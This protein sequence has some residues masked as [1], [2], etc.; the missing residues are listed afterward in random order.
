MLSGLYPSTLGCT[1]NGIEM[2]ED[3]WTL[4][5]ILQ[6]YG[7]HTANIGKL[8]FRNHS[9]R[10]H[11]EPHPRYGFD[12]LILSDEPG[13]Y[14]DAYIKWVAER[15]ASQVDTCRVSTP[16]AW[17]GV[18]V[19]KQPRNTHE[20]YLFEGPEDMTHS[21]FVSDEVVSFLK[22]RQSC[23]PFFAIAGFYAPHA[24]LNPPRRFVDMYDASVLPLP[25]KDEQQGPLPWEGLDLAD[26]HWQ[27]IKA[28]YYALITHVDDQIGGIFAALEE[29][30]LWDD[31]LII[32][33]AD[34]GEHLGDHGLIQKGPPGLDSC[35]H[36]PL[37]VKPPRALA[38]SA[39]RA[40]YSELIEAVDVAPTVLDYCGV[41]I[42]P[43]FQGR[44]FRTLL[45][46]G[47]YAPRRSAYIEYRDPFTSSWKTVRTKAYKYTV[48]TTE[49]NVT[50]ANPATGEL[51]FALEKDPYERRNVAGNPSFRSALHEMRAELLR[52]WFTV[53]NQYPLR[54]GRY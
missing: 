25:H 29:E 26:E 28:Y 8:H 43:Y 47:D 52:R 9:N 14:D 19:V 23:Q 38:G 39:L 18:P 3:V 32:F 22:R 36:V 33:T 44:S 21:A 1:A 4:P 53:E 7:Y 35:A 24:P 10:D 54:T 6:S 49:R 13:C 46:G 15:D 20:P 41:Q 30:G 16:P 51:L 17:E 37:I 31:T 5:G 34:H 11:R 12:T 50:P 45:V 2:P 40:G 27:Q 42:P 48:F